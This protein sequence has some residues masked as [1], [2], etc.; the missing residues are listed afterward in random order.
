[1]LE[2]RI[3]KEIKMKIIGSTLTSDVIT[4]V[5]MND[6]NKVV[7]KVV[8][9]T[10]PFFDKIKDSLKKGD[11]STAIQLVFTLE[12]KI[13]SNDKTIEIQNGV[14]YYKGVKLYNAL[15]SRLVSM[16][17][18]GYNT[19]PLENFLNNLM[20]NPSSTAVE[21]LY[22]FLEANSLAIT[23]DGHFLA[24]K[25]VNDD[26][27]SIHDGKTD[28]SIGKLVSMERN[29]VD[30]VRERTCS[31]GLHFASLDYCKNVFKGDTIIALKINPKDVVSIP[32]DYNN[33][34]G[35][36]CAY[37][38]IAVVTDEVK[39]QN[40]DPLSESSVCNVKFTYYD[41]PTEFCAKPYCWDDVR[42]NK[43]GRDSKGRFTKKA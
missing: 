8:D 27:T 19:K 18:E 6:V 30:D 38:P 9:K 39:N 32:K 29:Q 21:E 14:V 10:H 16:F 43:Q 13:P 23:D 24:Y 12:N 35:R 25:S 11:N 31:H 37:L 1:M 28:N 17:V 34:K 2:L 3:K 5:L 15:T 33:Q 7:N 20:Q 4:L 22:L 40:R 36:A 42:G 41:D 26:F